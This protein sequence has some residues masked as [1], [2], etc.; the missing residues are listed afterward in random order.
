MPECLRSGI[1]GAMSSIMKRR[2]ANHDEIIERI[3]ACIVADDPPFRG[4]VQTWT[5]LQEERVSWGKSVAAREEIIAGL[6]TAVNE[7]WF[8]TRKAN[9]LFEELE[10]RFGS[11]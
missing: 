2:K 4:E 6:V 7:D 9:Q 10:R 3:C 8:D 5:H 11:A 1:T